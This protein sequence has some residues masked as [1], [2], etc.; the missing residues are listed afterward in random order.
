MRLRLRATESALVVIDVQERLSAAMPAERMAQVTRN[1]SRLVAL[2]ELLQLPVCVSEQYPRGL[3]PTLAE[4]AVPLARVSPTKFEKVTFS[5]AD[6]PGFVEFAKN[7]RRQLIVVGMETHVCVYQSVRALCERGFSVHVPEDAVI[8]RTEENR[9]VG[10][11]LLALSGALRT[12]TE[13]VGFDLLERAGSDAFRA[14]S[15]LVK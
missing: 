9:A 7:G 14:W 3:G 2:A 8:S 10:L 6:E 1:I 15:S 4:L 12:S 11:R 5:M 13:T